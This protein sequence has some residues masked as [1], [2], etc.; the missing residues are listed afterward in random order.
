MSKK[1]SGQDPSLTLYPVRT[2][3]KV[4]RGR[5]YRIKGKI[6]RLDYS[7]LKSTK[8]VFDLPGTLEKDTGNKRVCDVTEKSHKR[9]I[10]L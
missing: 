10:L 7:S 3:D 4:K 2:G 9:Y 6:T 1:G 8:K 5:Y